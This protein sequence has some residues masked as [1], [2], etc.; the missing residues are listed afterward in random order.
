LQKPYSR[1][2]SFTNNDN[3]MNICN[4]TFAGNFIE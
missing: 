4:E 2:L 1:K 3:V